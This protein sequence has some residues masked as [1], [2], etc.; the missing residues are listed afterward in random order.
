MYKL[1]SIVVDDIV[2]CSSVHK[3][4]IMQ[5]RLLTFV[6]GGEGGVQK[7]PLMTKNER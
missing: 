1:I 7:R 5:N 6:R 4:A 2:L 3:L